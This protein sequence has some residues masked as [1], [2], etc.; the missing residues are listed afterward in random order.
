ML[1]QLQAGFAAAPWLIA[2]G[3]ALGLSIGGG[4]VY[5]FPYFG[6]ADTVARLK[7]AKEAA[8]GWEGNFDQAEGL[9]VDEANQ[10]TA[11]VNE[12]RD[13]GQARLDAF[14]ASTARRDAVINREPSYDQDHCPV[15]ELLSARELFNPVLSASARTGADGDGPEDLRR[16]GD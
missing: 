10:C 3:L 14:I 4:A 12:E 16:P 1:K 2:A 11:A 9:R 13:R 5:W 7:P 6:M 8:I 15:R